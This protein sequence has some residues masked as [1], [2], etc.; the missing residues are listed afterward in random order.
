MPFPSFRT[1]STIRT[2]LPSSPRPSTEV[3]RKARTTPGR[4]VTRARGAPAL[5]LRAEVCP[6]GSASRSR[7]TAGTD[8][9]G[10]GAVRSAE[11]GH[12][13]AGITMDAGPNGRSR[14]SLWGV[15]VLVAA[16]VVAEVGN[17]SR[18]ESP[19]HS[20]RSCAEAH[21]EAGPTRD[22]PTSGHSDHARSGDSS[23]K[24]MPPSHAMSGAKIRIDPYRPHADFQIIVQVGSTRMGPPY[25]HTQWL[26]AHLSISNL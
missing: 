9:A 17:F 11:E 12:P 8:R 25:R 14:A 7:A 19:R 13:R 1:R 16:A 2:S 21:P 6:S 4:R 20:W 24:P 22:V 5:D 3:E 18:L 10:R 23:T 26:L 15:S